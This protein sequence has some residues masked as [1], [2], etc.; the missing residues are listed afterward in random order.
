MATTTFKKINGPLLIGVLLI[1]YISCG[2]DNNSNP[3]ER[4]I[5]N[6]SD[7]CFSKSGGNS[8][9]DSKAL[10]IIYSIRRKEDLSLDTAEMVKI[11]GGTFNMGAN[12]QAREEGLAGTIPKRDEYPNNRIKVDDFWMDKNEVTN[13][14]FAE[15][16]SA[17]NYL[18]TAEQEI[19]TNEL[20]KQLP[21][22]TMLPDPE[23]LKPGSLVFVTL[24]K[25]QKSVGPNNWWSFEVGASWK[26][27]QGAQSNLK[28]KGDHP[29]VHVSWYD[30]IA[31]ARW[32]GKRLPT[33]VEW[34]YASRAGFD[35]KVYPWGDSLTTK[36]T[37][38]ANYWQ[39]QF[40]FTNNKSDNYMKTAPVRSYPPNAFG[41]YDMSGNIWEWCS[42]WYHHDYY[43]CLQHQ[44]E[45]TTSGPTSSYDP[46]ARSL[47]QKVL[48]GGSFLCND[49]YC[50]GYRNSA[51]MK[52]SPDTTLN[53]QAFAV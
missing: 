47:S 41:L 14:Q 10:S 17:T 22:G 40:P 6:P 36:D 12:D 25:E 39:G 8:H 15:F 50:S 51:R 29:V 49:S 5:T 27:P 1:T 21:P 16:V 33:E 3:K 24:P 30:A 2:T 34:E 37:Y 26:H 42:D 28:G 31:Y 9:L 32:A 44:D 11:I 53:I 20:K 43:T 52:S 18:T 45:K 46:S 48:R 4:K 35:D 38:L 13:D 23:L 19:D 7:L